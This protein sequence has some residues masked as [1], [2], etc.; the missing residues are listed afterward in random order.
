MIKYIIQSYDYSQTSTIVQRRMLI[1]IPY[2]TFP[3]QTDASVQ[4]I[5][6]HC[7]NYEM[8]QMRKY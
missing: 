4:D 1:Y 6:K 7:A 5:N 3:I 2:S 8:Q